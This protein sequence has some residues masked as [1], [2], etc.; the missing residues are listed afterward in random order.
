MS[1][2]PLYFMFPDVLLCSFTFGPLRASVILTFF[3][4][5]WANGQIELFQRFEYES[6]SRYEQPAA[7]LHRQ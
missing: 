4:V 6:I 1:N 7:Y 2:I 5:Q 3:T